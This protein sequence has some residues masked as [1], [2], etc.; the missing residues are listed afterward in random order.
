MNKDEMLT[1]ASTH[2]SVERVFHH[3]LGQI[4]TGILFHQ[5]KQGTYTDAFE[6]SQTDLKSFTSF[7]NWFKDL[8]TICGEKKELPMHIHHHARSA[9]AALGAV[10]FGQ[11]LLDLAGGVPVARSLHG[12]DAPSVA[13]QHGAETLQIKN[14]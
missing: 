7:E 2:V 9:E 4:L 5:S 12:G 13:G 3:L 11:L 6:V 1:G 8:W 10:V 14:H